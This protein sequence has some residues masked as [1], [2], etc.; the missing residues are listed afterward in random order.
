MHSRSCISQVKKS[1]PRFDAVRDKHTLLFSDSAEE[2]YELKPVMAIILYIPVLEKSMVNVYLC[3][4]V[5]I[6]RDG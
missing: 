3:I 4:F 6:Q 5:Q 2:N 1:A